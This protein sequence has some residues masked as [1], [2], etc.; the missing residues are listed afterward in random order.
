MYVCVVLP[1]QKLWGI[2]S[3]IPEA[4]KEFE[5]DAIV[6]SVKKNLS[7]GTY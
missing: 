4:R 7:V 2:I 6:K 3:L 5:I 1:E